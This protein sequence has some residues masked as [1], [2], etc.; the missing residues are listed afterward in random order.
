M[1]TDR[2]IFDETLDLEGDGGDV[3]ARRGEAGR[4]VKLLGEVLGEPER[5]RMGP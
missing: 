4:E 3:G 1:L 5:R 2:T